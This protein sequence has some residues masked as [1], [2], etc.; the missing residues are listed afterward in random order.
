MQ[1]NQHLNLSLSKIPND[2]VLYSNT[3]HRL[4]P[5]AIKC[6]TYREK[7]CVVF[8]N[9]LPASG[10][11][12]GGSSM[13]SSAGAC[14]DEN[15]LVE[16]P[17]SVWCSRRNLPRSSSRSRG[18]A[19]RIEGISL[20]GQRTDNPSVLSW[21]LAQLQIDRR[22]LSVSSSF[23]AI[24]LV[25]AGDAFLANSS[26]N[27]CRMSLSSFR[28]SSGDPFMDSMCSLTACCQ[29]VGS[30]VSVMFSYILFIQSGSMPQIMCRRKVF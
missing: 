29:R 5:A 13:S 18:S 9:D 6:P 19:T 16:R 14:T 12:R 27:A 4:R 24:K 7:P 30:S 1:S 20:F 2:G 11:R 3:F 21:P 26:W 17:F 10:S 23:S 8:L 22:V 28:T 15:V 25:R